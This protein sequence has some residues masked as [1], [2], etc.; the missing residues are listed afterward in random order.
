MTQL[1]AYSEDLDVHQP[2]TESRN[3]CTHERWVYNYKIPTNLALVF[4]VEVPCS[5]DGL[6][7][8]GQ[9]PRL[10]AAG[11]PLSLRVLDARYLEILKASLPFS[12]I[13][14]GACSFQFT[15]VKVLGSFDMV[16]TAAQDDV[17]TTR[18]TFVL[19]TRG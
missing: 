1:I 4:L 12:S 11:L 14:L 19:D 16:S 2:H 18:L 7:I 6:W 9:V 5:Y 15:S 10:V 17:T 3:E 8:H 13:S